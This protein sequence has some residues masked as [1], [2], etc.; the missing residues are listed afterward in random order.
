MLLLVAPL[1]EVKHDSD[2][3]DMDQEAILSDEATNFTPKAHGN[4]IK[5]V[6]EDF[7]NTKVSSLVTNQ[8]ADSC[9]VNIK[10]AKIL[11]IHHVNYHSHLLN[12]K[13]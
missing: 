6:M 5:Y 11:D 9:L 1:R 13:I 7:Y 3:D 8:A 10:L 4:Q 2:T 12:N